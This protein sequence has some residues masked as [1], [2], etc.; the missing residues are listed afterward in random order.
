MDHDI[1][2]SKTPPPMNYKYNVY[3]VEFW[4]LIIEQMMKD[5]LMRIV[6]SESC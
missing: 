4:Q 3:F 5:L 1:E 2:I 6:I